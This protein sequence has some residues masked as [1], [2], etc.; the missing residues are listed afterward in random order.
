MLPAKEVKGGSLAVYNG[1]PLWKSGYRWQ[2][3]YWGSYWQGK[4]IP[5]APKGVD[6]AVMDIEADKSYSG[7]LSEYNV[8]QG[9]VLP[10]KIITADPPSTIDD[11]QIGPQI[12]SWIK[13]GLIPELGQQGAYNI[14]FPPGT[15]VT[16]G[17]SASCQAFCDFHNTDGTHFYTVEPF[18]CASGCNQCTSSPFDTLTMGLSEELT[19]L[20]TD[21]NPGTGWVIGSEELCDFCD[22]NFKCERVTT[23]EYCLPPSEL[24]LGDNKQISQYEVGD[25]VVGRTGLESVVKTFERHYNGDLVE[26]KGTGLLPL[27][28]TPNHPVLVVRGTAERKGPVEYSSPVWKN[29]GDVL[30]KHAF[31]QGDYLV[32][33]RIIGR[34]DRSLF[35]LRKTQWCHRGARTYS[36]AFRLSSVSAWFVGLYVAEGCVYGRTIILTLHRKEMAFARR[37]VAFA[38]SMGYKA[39]I[40]R[41]SRNAIR[42]A[43]SSAPLGEFLQKHCGAGV[44]NKKIPEFILYNRDTRILQSFLAGYLSGDG[45]VNKR[46]RVIFNTVSKVL[47]EQIQLAWARLGQFCGIEEGWTDRVHYDRKLIY[48]GVLC[49]SSQ[50]RR[51]KIRDAYFIIPIQKVSRHFYVGRVYNIATRDQS[52]LVSNAVVH[53]CN[54]WYDNAKAACWSP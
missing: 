5:F 49:P 9:T 13:L 28:L 10:S 38:S 37:V 16:L 32:L 8:G 20:K 1:G 52:Y 33:P 4:T 34:M 40:R 22:E 3:I 21:M 36:R 50:H 35:P 31:L 12:A 14:F 54:A 46:N 42:V 47:A 27:K 18:P 53:N 30:E 26:V 15:T 7:G 2:N 41:R 44:K 19:E 45:H 23:G 25:S 48:R 24:V 17:G 29:A 6:K 43:F 11:S 39:T 51:V